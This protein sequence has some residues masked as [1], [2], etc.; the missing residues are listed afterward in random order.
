MNQPDTITVRAETSAGPVDVKA[1]GALAA[2]TPEPKLKIGGAIRE[3]TTPT[4]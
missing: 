1:S 3:V 4:R 2:G